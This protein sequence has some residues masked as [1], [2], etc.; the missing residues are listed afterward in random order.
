VIKQP[1]SPKQMAK[2]ITT[3]ENDWLQLAK[4]LVSEF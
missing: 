1:Y 3:S 2:R 4:H